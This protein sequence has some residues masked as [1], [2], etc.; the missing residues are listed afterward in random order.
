[1]VRATLESLAHQSTDL[2]RAMERDAGRRVRRLRVDGGAAA[3]DWLMQYQADVLGVPVERPAVIETTALGAGLLAGIAVGFWASQT[4]AARARRVEHVFR[5]RQRA[6]WRRGE[7]E[8]WR[9]AVDCL[10]GPTARP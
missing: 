7:I 3:N 10:L 1:V 4:E 5:P 9:A 6:A 2:V 8:R